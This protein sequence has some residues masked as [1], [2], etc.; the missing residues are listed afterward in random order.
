M[1]FSLIEKYL[2][3]IE[4]EKGFSSH[5]IISYKTD[6]L[7]FFDFLEKR[8]GLKEIKL[9]SIDFM[10]VRE[11][12]LFL[13]D[14]ENRTSSSV[15]RKLSV[16]K[17]F[18]RYLKQKGVVKDNPMQQVVSLKRE[19]RLPKF[20]KESEVETLLTLREEYFADDF[21]GVRDATIIEAFY[22]L[23]IRESELI[24]IKDSDVDVSGC[25]VSVLGKGRKRRLIPFGVK[26]KDSFLNYLKAREKLQLGKV[27]T[28]FIRKDGKPL[29]PMLVYRLVNKYLSEVSSLTQRSPH[30]LRHTFATLMLN[31][32]AEL[33]AVKELLGHANLAATEV[34]THTTFE[35][36]REIYKRAHPRAD[37]KL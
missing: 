3:Y 15:N 36:L 23:G 20:L 10:S 31:N 22:T 30:V 37:K 2:Q 1:T 29:Y 13:K 35:Q 25:Y 26:M 14:D 9:E 33:N 11:W 18:F 7:Q 17:S 32:G 6:L 27:D 34:Y 21:E 8:Q 16:L 4:Y 19:A 5:T 12:I 24:G 28:F